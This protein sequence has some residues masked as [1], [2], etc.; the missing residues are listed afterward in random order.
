ARHYLNVTNPVVDFTI[1]DSGRMTFRNAAVDLRFASPAEEYRIRWARFDNATGMAD[2]VGDEIVV[3]EP[4]ATIPRELR[5]AEYVRAIV[6]SHHAQ[7]PNWAHAVH[8]FFRKQGNGW[9]TVGLERI[10][11]SRDS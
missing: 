11:P 5:D 10:V 6:T 4:G 7:Q 1:D 3:K 9:K 2:T 8:I